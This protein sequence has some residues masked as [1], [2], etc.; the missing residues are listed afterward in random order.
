MLLTHPKCGFVKY[1]GPHD[2][3]TPVVHQTLGRKERVIDPAHLGV[4][5][6]IELLILPFADVIATANTVTDAQEHILSPQLKEF[7]A[8][9][10]LVERYTL[11]PMRE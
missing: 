10:V 4:R 3:T 6:R 11:D 1:P 5:L 7:R 2:S 9:Y 8:G